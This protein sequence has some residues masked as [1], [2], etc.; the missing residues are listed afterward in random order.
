MVYNYTTF[1]IALKK[2]YF[3]EEIFQL[4]QSL[5]KFTFWYNSLK[6]ARY[7]YNEKVDD[8]LQGQHI[9]RYRRSIWRDIE[10][11]DGEI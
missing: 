3:W 2:L 5:R 1:W 6:F 4:F 10:A 8:K 9:T 7:F 11:V